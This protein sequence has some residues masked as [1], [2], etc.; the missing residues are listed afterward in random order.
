MIVETYVCQSFQTLYEASPIINVTHR[1][2]AAFH[3]IMYVTQRSFVAPARAIRDFFWLYHTYSLLRGGFYINASSGFDLW[4]KTLRGN[5]T[6]AQP[7]LFIHRQNR[8]T[9][10]FQG[11][12]LE[13]GT[14]FLSCLNQNQHNYSKNT[15]RLNCCSLILVH[16]GVYADV[17]NLADKLLFF[18]SS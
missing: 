12:E 9:N 10:P 3:P 6:R 13:F 17:Y 14:K 7:L 1:S 4:A 8:R 16:E 11:L 18:I 2:F 15:F 5:Y